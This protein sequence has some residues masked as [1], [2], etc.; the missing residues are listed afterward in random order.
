[1]RFNFFDVATGR[2]VDRAFIRSRL[3]KMR[4]L[5]IRATDQEPGGKC[6]LGVIAL[7]AWAG[8]GLEALDG[9]D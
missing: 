9:L 5:G 6:D 3:I 2:E 8:A 1:M 7:L 4:D